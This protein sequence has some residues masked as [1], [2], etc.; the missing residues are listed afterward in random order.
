MYIYFLLCIL[1]CKILLNYFLK[2]NLSINLTLI[3]SM[4]RQEIPTAEKNLQV[5]A[6]TSIVVTKFV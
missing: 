4:F 1:A 5:L 2:L 6:Y 3:I